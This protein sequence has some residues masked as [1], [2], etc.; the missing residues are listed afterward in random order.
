MD[1]LKWSNGTKPEKS[2]KKDRFMKTS[3]RREEANEKLS[4]RDPMV[5]HA[6]NPFF[7]TSNFVDDFEVQNKFF[8]S[9]SE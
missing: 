3:S 4:A 6:C 5:Q 9:S 1:E 7:S 8:N 2:L